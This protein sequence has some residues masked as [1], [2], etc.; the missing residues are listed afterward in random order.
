MK[1]KSLSLLILM[2]LVISCGPSRHAI[3]VE[4]RHPSRS[5]IEL[6]GKNLSVVYVSGRDAKDDKVSEN[7]ADK[8]SQ[9]LEQS[10]G[11]G[12]GSVVRLPVDCSNADYAG[13]DSLLRIL[14]RTG[15]DAVFLL[16]S[17]EFKQNSP[18]ANPLKLTLYC[19]DGMNK[20]DKVQTFS[21]TTVV[22]LSGNDEI[23]TEAVKT[24]KLIAESFVSQ[25][26]HEQYSVV[27]YNG[28][29]W[30]DALVKAEQFDWKGAVDIW[31]ELLDTNDLM[32]RAAAEY[33]ISVACY[34]LGDFELAE[35]WL[36]KSKADNDMPTLTDAMLKRIRARM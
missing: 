35:A 1:N 24:G 14:M 10:Y 25:W 18:S 22:S 33:N 8:F 11:T 23:E 21:G 30:Y 7:M 27:Y 26:K 13:K 20:E 29:N 3:H 17:P 9:A 12:E 36:K 6:A 16:A 15:A 34:M 5:G 4:M 31:L 32:K 2:L 28:Q 19:Y